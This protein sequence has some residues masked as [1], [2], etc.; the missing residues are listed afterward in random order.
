MRPRAAAIMDVDISVTSCPN[1]M[2]IEINIL[3]K[4][5]Q[6]YGLSGSSGPFQSYYAPSSAKASKREHALKITCLVFFDRLRKL[7]RMF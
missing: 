4:D 1:D 6:L 2:M 5:G 7:L 3:R